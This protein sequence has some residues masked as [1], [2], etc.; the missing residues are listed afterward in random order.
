MWPSSWIELIAQ[1][2]EVSGERAGFIRRKMPLAECYQYQQIW[3]SKNGLFPIRPGY[4]NPS[5]E[6]SSLL[7]G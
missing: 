6:I 1:V 3:F 7:K 5:R 4:S 2:S